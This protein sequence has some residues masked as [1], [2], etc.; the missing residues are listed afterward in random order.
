MV[1]QGVYYT[2]FPFN[3]KQYASAI[4]DN[5]PWARAKFWRPPEGEQQY[6]D[7]MWARDFSITWEFPECVAS[8]RPPST[9]NFPFASWSC[10]CA[11]LLGA[12]CLQHCK[13][14]A[15]LSMFPRVWD[16]SLQPMSLRLPAGPHML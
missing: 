10:I 3:A 4:E 13:T 16:P 12:C 5:G 8:C 11:G 14:I 1:P 2:N 9:L 15:R 7:A 6:G